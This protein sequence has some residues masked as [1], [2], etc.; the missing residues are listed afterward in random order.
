MH[1]EDLLV[2]Y[3]SDGQAIKAVGKCLPKLDVVSPLAL[4]VEAINAVDGGTLV[5]TTEDEEILWVFDL[6]C[7]QEADGLKRLL[8][9]IDIVSEK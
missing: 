8:A 5:I 2:N 6:V 3:G 4:V 7:Q 1:R 9:S